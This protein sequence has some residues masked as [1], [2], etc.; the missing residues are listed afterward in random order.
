M[1]EHPGHSSAVGLM[2]AQGHLGRGN[3][4]WTPW[5][6]DVPMRKTFDDD[7]AAAQRLRP[8]PHDV[9]HIAQLLPSCTLDLEKDP[10]LGP[11]KY[12]NQINYIKKTA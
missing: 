10:R 11:P 4:A 1:R 3:S 6:H 8:E 12:P 5:S 2:V 7:D 9:Y